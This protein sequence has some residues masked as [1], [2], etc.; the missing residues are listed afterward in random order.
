MRAAARSAG[1]SRAGRLRAAAPRS[2]AS[3]RGRAGHARLARA[4][5]A[6]GDRRAVER[7]P[8]LSRVLRSGAV[9]WV[10][11]H[12]R[13]GD[14]VGDARRCRAPGAFWSARSRA[15]RGRRRSRSPAA[16][17]GG[18]G[19]GREPLGAGGGVSAARRRSAGSAP[20][21]EARRPSRPAAE[22]AGAPRRSRSRC[23]R[24][25]LPRPGA[26]VAA[27]RLADDQAAVR[28]GGRSAPA[29]ACCWRCRAGSARGL[30]TLAAW[31]IA[32]AD[33]LRGTDRR[34]PAART[35]CG[36]PTGASFATRR[37]RGR[38]DRGRAAAV[39]RRQR[40]GPAAASCSVLPR[41][42]RS[43]RRSPSGPRRIRGAVAGSRA[44]DPADRLRGPGD[45]RQPGRRAVLG[46]GPPPARCRLAVDRPARGGRR[47]LALAVALGAGVLALPIAARLNAEPW[48]TTGTGRGSGPSASVDSV[49]PRLRAARLA[50]RRHDDDDGR[51]Q[52]PLYWKASVL[53]RFD[54]YRWSARRSG[55]PTAIAELDARAIVPGAGLNQLHP[56]WVEDATFELAGLDAASS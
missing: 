48:W 13:P 29:R 34:R 30:R 54:G 15:A 8:V 20:V 44:R 22:A 12:E 17:A 38:R 45:A 1:T 7:A 52:P 43:P 10:T 11:A 35:C 40:V 36:P 39:R 41:S 19:P 53:D 27:G 42:S 16:R 56:G 3:G 50:A 51:D 37:R 23:S 32:I 5:R 21:A 25:W 47:D 49:E 28:A 14:P 9:F 33:H 18:S 55:D 31:A 26:V 6:P 4:A 24:P 46:P 2:P